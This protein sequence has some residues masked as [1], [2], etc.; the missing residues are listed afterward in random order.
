MK[1]KAWIIIRCK[2]FAS[3]LLAVYFFFDSSTGHEAINNYIVLLA[4]AI[5]SINTLVVS[6]VFRAKNIRNYLAH[7]Q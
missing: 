6:A 2:G 3:Y 7:M 1:Q 4:N 5:C